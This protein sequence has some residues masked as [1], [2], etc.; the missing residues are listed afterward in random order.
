M[1]YCGSVRDGHKGQ[2]E[3][4]YAWLQIT[5][6]CLQLYTKSVLYDIL[7]NVLLRNKQYMYSILLLLCFSLILRHMMLIIGVL[8]NCTVHTGHIVG[9]TGVGTVHN[10]DSNRYLS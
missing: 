5:H 4:V 6:L 2:L 10:V 9:N 1:G 3:R 7:A 8:L